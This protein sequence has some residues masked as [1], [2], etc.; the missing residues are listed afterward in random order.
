MF[1]MLQHFLFETFI[2]SVQFA[3]KCLWK[4]IG[5]QEDLYGAMQ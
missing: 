3:W 4:M 1:Q 2:E 5:R